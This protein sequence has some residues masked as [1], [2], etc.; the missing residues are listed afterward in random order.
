MTQ[1]A[2]P[3][4]TECRYH[5]NKIDNGTFG[6]AIKYYSRRPKITRLF[7]FVTNITDYTI[8]RKIYL[9]VEIL[10]SSLAEQFF[11]KLSL[12]ISLKHLLLLR[13][14]IKHKIC[15]PS[16]FCMHNFKIMFPL[17]MQCNNVVRIFIQVNIFFIP[18][19]NYRFA[20]YKKLDQIICG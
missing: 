2:M 12:T 4:R 1:Q 3:A 6:R 17:Q 13:L 16:I 5:K 8:Q 10:V 20:I 9:S 19:I 7:I 15:Q 11:R 18:R 14:Y